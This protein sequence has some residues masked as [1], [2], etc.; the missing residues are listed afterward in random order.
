[1]STKISKE[2][3]SNTLSIY[4]NKF[5][6]IQSQ[7]ENTGLIEEKNNM[8]ELSAGGCFLIANMI[9]QIRSLNVS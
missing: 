6:Q 7:W 2:I 8:Y 4:G 3:I 5:K 1:M 9:N